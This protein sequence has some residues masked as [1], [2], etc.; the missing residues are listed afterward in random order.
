M[1]SY[2]I[3]M[4]SDLT[5]HGIKG[6]KWGVRRYRNED[7]TLTEAGKRRYGSSADA[8]ETYGKAKEKYQRYQINKQTAQPDIARTL[9]YSGSSMETRL[10][11]RSSAKEK[12]DEA[13]AEYV[14][15][16]QAKLKDDNLRL[17]KKR[18]V[19]TN[20]DQLT[21]QTKRTAA[22]L[23]NIAQ[24]REQNKLL[25]KD[26]SQMTDQE[27][28]DV[29]NRRNLERQYLQATADQRARGRDYVMDVLDVAGGVLGA[30]GSA[31][32]IAIAINTLRN[33]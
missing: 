27:M 16:K 4:K 29:I 13:K 1:K 14:S 2:Q 21:Q 18:A 24:K 19:V 7:G 25:G 20:A 28:R 32:A 15:A 17:T 30:T 8:R 33:K 26:L 22:G 3:V 31:L 23:R 12:M 9:G 5:H 10:A 11:Q 6:Q